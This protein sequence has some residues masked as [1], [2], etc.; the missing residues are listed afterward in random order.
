MGPEAISWSVSQFPN[1]LD[2]DFPAGTLAPWDSIAVTVSRNA[3]ITSFSEPQFISQPILFTNLDSPVAQPRD[4]ELRVI[5]APIFTET[6]DGNSLDPLKWPDSSGGNPAGIPLGLFEPTE[7]FYSAIEWAVH[8]WRY[9]ADGPDRSVFLPYGLP[10]LLVS[11]ARRRRL[12]TEP[13]E[14]LVFEYWTGSS[15]KEVSRQAGGP[16]DMTN[17][18]RVDLPLAGDAI[19][20]GFRLPHSVSIERE[21]R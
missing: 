20:A 18:S 11:A 2:V 7:P 6:F 13:G 16:A 15:W 21:P 10:D 9:G 5:A 17:Y 3:M 1:W 8:W 4:M 14:D 19:H 12:S